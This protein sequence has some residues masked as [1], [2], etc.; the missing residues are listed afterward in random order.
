MITKIRYR[1]CYNYSGKLNSDGR[2]PVAVE[3]R[4]GRQRAYF[5]SNILIYPEQWSRG[6]IINHDNSEKMTVYLHRWMHQ[7]EEIELDMLLRGKP[8]SL[9]QLKVSFKSGVRANA[10][11]SEFKE[12]VISNDSSRCLNTKRSYS[13]LINDLEKE[14]G[15]LSVSDVTYDLIIR[16]RESMRKRGLS[17]NTVKGRLKELRCLMEQARLRDL[18]DKNPFDNITIGNIGGR[19][20]GLTLSEVRRIE[21]LELSGKE[22]KVRDLFL[23]SCTTGLRWGDLSTLEEADI[24]NGI[25]RKTMHKTHHDVVIPIGSLFNGKPLEIIKKYNDI[26]ELSHCCSNT[27]ANKIL[28]EIAAKAN[29]KKRVY[30]HI[31][32][33]TFSQLLNS[34]GMDMSDISILMGHCDTRTTRTHYV[35]NDEERV[36]KSVKKLFREKAGQGQVTVT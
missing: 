17:E 29:I 12:S 9:S 16:Y 34:L 21:R 31:G 10:S 22:E 20:G 4:Q 28:K 14:F 7:I 6:S 26:R 19:T 33:K 35:F 3:A 25:L 30:N 18:I 36:K 2:A 5:S 13:Y 11:L 23:L 8:M 15:R 1:L 27:T 24:K 32:R